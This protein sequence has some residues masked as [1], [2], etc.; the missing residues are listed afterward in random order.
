MAPENTSISGKRL[1]EERFHSPGQRKVFYVRKWL[2]SDR[3]G[4]EHQN[5]RCFI[6]LKHQYVAQ[7]KNNF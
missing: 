2:N 3:I 5:G 4:S 7:W 6:V 1:L